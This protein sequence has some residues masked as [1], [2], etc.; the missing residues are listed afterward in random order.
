MKDVIAKAIESQKKKI[1]NNRQKYQKKILTRKK[2]EAIASLISAI[3]Q[4]AQAQKSEQKKEK[5]INQILLVLNKKA[6][7]Q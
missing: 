3:K 6:R 1:K 7:N 5:L 4:N 2:K